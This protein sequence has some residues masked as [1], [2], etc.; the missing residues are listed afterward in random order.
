MHGV[1]QEL[2]KWQTQLVVRPHFPAAAVCVAVAGFH[3]EPSSG[4]AMTGW[5]QDFHGDQP[6]S[7][8]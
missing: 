3:E 7:H 6:Q 1:G 8:Q 2:A 4:S 5:D